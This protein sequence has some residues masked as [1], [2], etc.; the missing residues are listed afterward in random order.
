MKTDAHF[1]KGL[2]V[3]WCQI[4]RITMAA[5][6]AALGLLGV[7]EWDWEYIWDVLGICVYFVS[8]F[9]QKKQKRDQ[10]HAESR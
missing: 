2:Y 5:L 1:I 4:D 9:G 7:C 8:F 6:S 3:E 10:L